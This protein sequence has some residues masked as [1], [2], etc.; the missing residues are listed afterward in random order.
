MLPTL[1]LGRH[2]K[3]QG[4]EDN[5]QAGGPEVEDKHRPGQYSVDQSFGDLHSRLKSHNSNL[6]SRNPNSHNSNK[7]LQLGEESESEERVG[8]PPIPLV[9]KA[10]GEVDDLDEDV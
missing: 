3:L 8:L 5:L 7:P 2:L 4:G 9:D 6:S 10:L 1:L